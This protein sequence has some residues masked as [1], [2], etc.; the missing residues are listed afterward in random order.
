[1]ANQRRELPLYMK[2]RPYAKYYYKE[3]AIP[4]SYKDEIGDNT[5]LSPDK[6]LRVQD[7]SKL[8]EDIPLPAKR[9]WSLF[10]DGTA[11]CFGRM[12]FPNATPEMFTW[13]FAWMLVDPLR[14][15]IWEPI[16][17][18]ELMVTQDQLAKLVDYTLPVSERIWDV[19]FFPIDRGVQ[20][21]PNAEAQPNRTQFYSPKEFG[22][23][24]DLVEKIKGKA[25]LVMAQCGPIGQPP[26]TSFMH[27]F[28]PVEGG[29]ELVSYFWYGWKIVDGKP[30]KAHITFPEKVLTNM[31]KSQTVH[32]IDEYYRLAQFLPD[33]YNTYRD[34]PENTWDFV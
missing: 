26:V 34:I 17:H 3:Y 23:D 16:H 5:P 15:K 6:M 28:R 29:M 22:L 8:L 32:L 11:A 33:L 24:M 18:E 13:W 2:L 1:M 9:G 20:G 12:F 21:D 14:G 25:D 19:H 30:S 4:Q 31:C 7:R 27:Y 10:E